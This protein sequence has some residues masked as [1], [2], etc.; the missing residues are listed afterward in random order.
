MAAAFLLQSRDTVSQPVASTQRPGRIYHADDFA[1]GLQCRREPPLV[2]S[3][4]ASRKV[5]G[6]V[7]PG[8]AGNEESHPNGHADHGAA[9]LNSK[10]H[11][12]G[13]SS[14]SS[15]LQPRSLDT[16][17]PHPHGDAQ[18]D[19]DV[20]PK[21]Q[22]H[23]PQKNKAPTKPKP[24]AKPAAARQERGET[25]PAAPS[26]DVSLLQPETQPP[27]TDAAEG[28]RPGKAAPLVLDG[29]QRDVE[30]LAQCM[31]CDICREVLLDP[32]HSSTCMHCYCRDCIDAFL[33]LGGTSNCC[34]VCQR[35]DVATSLGRDPYKDN[36]K[37]DFVLSNLIRKVR[38]PQQAGMPRSEAVD[39]CQALWYTGIE[40]FAG[41]QMVQA[42]VW[43]L[44][45]AALRRALSS[46]SCT[47]FVLCAPSW[48]LCISVRQ[49]LIL[50]QVFPGLAEDA[51]CSA[52]RQLKRSALNAALTS[53][54]ASTTAATTD[55]FPKRL[56]T[57]GRD[58]VELFVSGP[59]DPQ[60]SRCVLLE[61]C[62]DLPD[63]TCLC[64]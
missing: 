2:A 16:T 64:L 27:T 60:P 7:A 1:P 40:K 24:K 37:L 56:R 4:V 12:N 23:K 19:D 15:M 43:P 53:Q 51:A 26:A 6:Y 17:A 22:A 54:R 20:Q 62:A 3:A 25:D 28:P 39:S 44:K 36:L 29:V 42:G 52:A 14:Q 5:E 33:V 38:N 18:P 46:M 41:P 31:A 55:R 57:D 11:H 35:A 61:V 47:A 50:L 34:P 32:V 8:P 58:V 9:A 13:L 45:P 63:V 10:P 48:L 21:R 30:A 49:D 59:G